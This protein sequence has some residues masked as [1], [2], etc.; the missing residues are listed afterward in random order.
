MLL[1]RPRDDLDV[2][3]GQL[4]V[5]IDEDDVAAARRLDP[6]VTRVADAAPLRGVEDRQPGQPRA[7]RLEDAR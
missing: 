4:I 2:V 7:V 6:P 5:L 1:Q 3:V